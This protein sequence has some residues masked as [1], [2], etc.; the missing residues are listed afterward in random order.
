MTAVFGLL[1]AVLSIWDYPSRFPQHQ[2][3]RAKL[4]QAVRAGD[5]RGMEAAARSGVEL[6]PDDATWAYNLAC[7]LAYREDPT[8][9]LEQLE[10]AIDLGFRD[11]KAIAADA[12]LQRLAK[13]RR[14]KD[15]LEYAREIEGRP[16][17]ADPLVAVPATGIWG[18]SLALG[19]QNFSWDFD[20]G[21]FTASLLMAP[22]KGSGGNFGDL[23]MNRDERHSLLTV[24][25]FP[26]LTEIRLD[27]AGR[28]RR[29]DL[30]FPNMS[31]NAPVFGNCS[32]AFLHPVYWRSIP[33]ALM[34][35]DAWRMP[36]MAKLY[37]SNQTWVFPVNADYPPIGTNDDCF[38]S[39]APYWLATQG[40]SWSDQ[41]YLRAALEASRSF[42]PAVKREMVERGLLA[43]TIQ[44][45]LRR[46]LKGVRDEEDYLSAK[47]HPTCLPPNGL[48]LP[49]LKA[50]AAALKAASIPPV[51]TLQIRVMPTGGSALAPGCLYAT[52]C[53][54]AFILRAKA[55]AHSFLLQAVGGEAYT[56]RQVHGEPSAVKFEPMG[57]G[58]MMVTLRPEKMVE[59]IDLAVFAKTATSEWGAPSYVSFSV[60]AKAPAYVDP[61][62][63]PS[64]AE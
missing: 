18:E 49:R 30:D 53:A 44:C 27:Q 48:D 13:N 14:F 23:Y 39:I 22:G 17:L 63:N 62:L 41:Y 33:R 4:V 40:R 52:P 19:E 31:F 50:A 60:P 10:R 36:L 61:A 59:R 56:F 25:N 32:R 8:E 2:Q 55:G 34:T 46:A 58:R 15:L 45:L 38:A 20:Y 7:A 6:L 9:A 3:L 37:L 24:T 1:L 28:A 35:T 51:A 21:C 54:A 64:P 47:A 26:G 5:T 42:A 12:D 57:P 16:V 43:P 11:V 29:M